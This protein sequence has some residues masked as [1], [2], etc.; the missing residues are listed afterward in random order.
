MTVTATTELEAVNVMLGVITEAPVTSLGDDTI[1]DAAVALTT[2]REVSRQFQSEGWHFNTDY[3]YPLAVD[4]NSKIPVP[5]SAASV[6]ASAIEGQD[7]D[8]VRRGGFLYDRVNRTFTFGDRTSLKCDIVWLYDFE[9]LPQTARTYITLMA[10][11]RF[12]KNVMG[13]EVSVQYTREDEGMA[14]AQFMA[15]NLRKADYNM[16]T[17]SYS[18]YRTVRRRQPWPV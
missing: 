17:D 4:G 14:R 16:L 10:A 12:A 13:D 2:L 18:V 1:E 11:R 15:D 6:D 3:E 5:T 7:V 9:D 8:V